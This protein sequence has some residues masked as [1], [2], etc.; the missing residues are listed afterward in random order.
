MNFELVYIP[1]RFINV[2][3]FLMEINILKMAN[4]VFVLLLGLKFDSLIKLFKF[5]FYF[6]IAPRQ[7]WAVPQ[8]LL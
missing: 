4:F 7:I 3:E 5:K 1:E 8:Q 2:K 6:F